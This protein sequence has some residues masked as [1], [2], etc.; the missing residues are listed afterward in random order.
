MSGK[1]I[2]FVKISKKYSLIDY[3]SRLFSQEVYR[4]I[5]FKATFH[6]NLILYYII[7]A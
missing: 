3:V 2:K 1:I 5:S 4:Y 7:L 6:M